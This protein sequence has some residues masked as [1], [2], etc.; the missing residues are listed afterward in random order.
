[1]QLIYIVENADWGGISNG[2]LAKEMMIVKDYALTNVLI[3]EIGHC[4]NLYHTHELKFGQELVDGSNCVT[5][6]DL[7]CDTPADPDLTFYHNI[8]NS[9]CNATQPITDNGITYFPD[10]KNIM[11]YTT[12]ECMEHFTDGQLSRMMDALIY[13]D[14]LKDV[15]T[16]CNSET[17]TISQTSEVCYSDPL[18][19]YLEN[20]CFNTNTTWETSG[21]IEVI[22]QNNFSIAIKAIGTGVSELGWVKATFDNSSQII[23]QELQVGGPNYYIENGEIESEEIDI[24]YQRWTRLFLNNVNELSG[25]EW[26]VDYS[27]VRPSDAPMILIYPLV[28]GPIYARVR[29]YYSCGCGPWLTEYFEVIQDGPHKVLNKKIF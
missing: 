8:I 13:S 3:H 12:P 14:V 17:I 20:I 2:V 6:G 24:Y 19:L 7:I 26:E 10:T 4:I 22:E 1:M 27:N 11:S 5:A 15:I 18:V 9:N 29:L 16:C 28:T 23:Y 25:W 21:N